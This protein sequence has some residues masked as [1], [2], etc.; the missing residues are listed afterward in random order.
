MTTAPTNVHE[1]GGP[2]VPRTPADVVDASITAA[3]L[4]G[5][6]G[7]YAEAIDVLARGAGDV[8]GF[9]VVALAMRRESGD[10]E[11]VSFVGD[12]E[13]RAMVLGKHLPAA[14]LVEQTE[15]ADAW[16]PLRFLPAERAAPTGFSWTPD[17]AKV[18]HPDA[19][20]PDDWFS[21]LLLRP[22]GELA[23][24]LTLDVP[25][26][27]LRPD[28]D[29]RARL[30]DYVERTAA[31]LENLDQRHRVEQQLALAAA[32]REVIRRADPR[33]GARAVVEACAPALVDALGADA[34]WFHVVDGPSVVAH[35]DSPDD[36]RVVLEEAVT[37]PEELRLL[38]RVTRHLWSHQELLMRSLFS[39]S[40]PG[41]SDD[42]LAAVDAWLER[43]DV[44]T[45]LVVPLG[46]RDEPLGTVVLAR[47][48]PQRDWSDIEERAARD[49]GDDLGDALHTA[50]V[51]AEKRA[52]VGYKEQ[53]I[54]T[55][56]HELKNPITAVLGNLDVLAEL[57][58]PTPPLDASRRAAERMGALV[59][60]LLALSEADGPQAVP[61]E[62]ARFDEAVVE[63]VEMLRT[64]AAAKEQTLVVAVPSD[65]VPVLVPRGGLDRVLGNLV[66]NAIKYTPEGGTVVVDLEVA[67]AVGDSAATAVLRVVDTGIG[68]AEEDLGR[69]FNA[70][71]RSADPVARRETGTGLGLAIVARTVQRAGG[72]VHV[73][74]V[75]GEGSTFTATLPLAAPAVPRG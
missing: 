74:S 2:A 69:V 39:R 8:A 29:T 4:H 30:A 44:T 27:G 9:G 68:I 61:T 25:F 58:A 20:D 15:E 43:K 17:L 41:I 26:D 23:G 71:V 38:T 63:T 13:G 11:F 34:A 42:D 22:D 66:G 7:R 50:A 3:L 72:S 46:T 59:D 53:L 24:V 1:S 28:A 73:D 36:R 65:P 37:T 52:M 51:F 33:Q 70:F 49:L 14:A 55:V 5:V 40:H 12:E 19:W 60:D 45:V 57:I 48:G 6:A 56:A 75:H 10:H 62:P 21:A 64:V 32:S 54:A 31:V 16:G 67:P 47:S 18:D 35:R